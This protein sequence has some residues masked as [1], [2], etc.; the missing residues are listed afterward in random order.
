MSV[1]DE[2]R[3]DAMRCDEMLWSMSLLVVIY[4]PESDFILHT[5]YFYPLNQQCL[6]KVWSLESQLSQRTAEFAEVSHASHQSMLN[7][8]TQ[9]LN[10]VLAQQIPN[11]R[12]ISLAREVDTLAAKLELLLKEVKERGAHITFLSTENQRLSGIVKS[13]ATTAT[14]VNASLT[15][16][17]NSLSVN[18][19]IRYAAGRTAH[20]PNTIVNTP[21]A[22]N[23]QTTSSAAAPSPTV[24]TIRFFPTTT[25]ISFE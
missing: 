22:N 20:D 11:E 19:A 25:S 24:S 9:E 23:S 1:R 8:R 2:M 16:S 4:L 7:I 14:A 21:S 17:S 13:A 18:P 6:G 12:E 15:R 10:H 3:C 5:S